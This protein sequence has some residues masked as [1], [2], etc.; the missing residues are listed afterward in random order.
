ME[1]MQSPGFYSYIAKKTRDLLYDD[2]NNNS[3]EFSPDVTGFAFTS[4]YKNG[5]FMS[6]FGQQQKHGVNFKVKLKEDRSEDPQFSTTII[7]DP[8][9]LPGLKAIINMDLLKPRVIGLRYRNNWAGINMSVIRSTRAPILNFSGLVREKATS[10]GTDV[11]FDTKTG[12]ATCSAVISFCYKDL[13]ASFNLNKKGN[14]LNAFYYHEVRSKL[15]KNM[16]FIQRAL[17]SLSI[18]A[19]GAEATHKF[20]T[21][22]S[23]IT[24]GTQFAL[25]HDATLKARA[26]N[27]GMAS[28]VI[29]NKWNEK[30]FVT[31]SGEVD[32]GAEDRTPKFG[33]AFCTKS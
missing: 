28:A 12:L 21:S 33:I 8:Y 6:T 31:I 1:K 32:I 2:H 29:E 26:N 30:T 4:A 20:S 11:S 27:I 5:E 22:E 19:V 15:S 18:T 16:N 9:F 24:I 25:S 10:L 7:V 14:T 13:I 17:A 3:L 23:A